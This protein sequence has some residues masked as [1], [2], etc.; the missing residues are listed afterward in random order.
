VGGSGS[1][2]HQGD[3]ATEDA[4]EGHAAALSAMVVVVVLC[5]AMVTDNI[6]TREVCLAWEGL[7]APSTGRTMPAGRLKSF[8]GGADGAAPGCI[9]MAKNIVNSL[10]SSEYKN[11]RTNRILRHQERCEIPCYPNRELVARAAVAE[12]ET[13]RD[14]GVGSECDGESTRR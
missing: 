3:C 10:N 14:G 8:G 7:G 12:V 6:R 9:I 5:A 4:T 2:K 1:T 11:H 13:S